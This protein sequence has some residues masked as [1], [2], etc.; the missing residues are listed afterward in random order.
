MPQSNEQRRLDGR[1]GDIWRGHCSGKTNEALA[2][3]YGISNQRVSQILAKIRQDMPAEDRADLVRREVDLLDR[4]R[5]EVLELWDAPPKPAYSNGRM[6]VDEDGLP[7]PDHSARLAA[8]DRAVRLHERLS[9][10]VGLDAAQKTEATVKVDPED[11][12]VVKRI[13]E[14]KAS[15]GDTSG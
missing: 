12:E 8:V 7:I 2:A 14:W 5:R 13:R 4:L 6:M 11:L 9:K 3:E 15:Q 10:L 1:N